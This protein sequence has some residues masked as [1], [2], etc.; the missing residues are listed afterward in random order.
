VLVSHDLTLAAEVADR[1]L[2]LSQGRL[3]GLGTPTEVLDEDVLGRVYGCRVVVS[4]SATS[5]RPVVQIAW[6]GSTARAERR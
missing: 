3:V 6:P 5:G 4:P 1:L 2:L